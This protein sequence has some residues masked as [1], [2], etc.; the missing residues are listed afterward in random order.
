MDSSDP[1]KRPRAGT[2]QVQQNGIL[3]PIVGMK[4]GR[5]EPTASCG[6]DLALR[7]ARA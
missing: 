5:H 2:K 1:I 7:S 6:L 3:T 4:H